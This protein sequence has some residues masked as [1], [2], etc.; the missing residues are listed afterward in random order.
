MTRAEKR[1]LKASEGNPLL[2]L[3][4]VQNHFYKTLW[5]DFNRIADP[6][7]A[8][9]INYSSDIMLAMPIM[10]NICDIRRM[11]GMTRT[12]NKEACIANIALITNND[13]L[14]E[15]PHY[16]TVN[17]FMSRLNPEELSVIRAKMIKS[18]IR[19]RSFL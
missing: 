19:K 17:H 13:G 4:K 18:L 14:E 3:L 9:Y 5:S 12:F 2:E 15:L 8:S 11:Q 16:V 10:K 6:R 7:H 1:Q